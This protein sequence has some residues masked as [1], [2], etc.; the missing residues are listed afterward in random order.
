VGETP[1]FLF[2]I[3]TKGRNNMAGNILQLDQLIDEL[4]A[5][6]DDPTSRRFYI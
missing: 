3:H 6:I 4:N 2:Y 5:F 1:P